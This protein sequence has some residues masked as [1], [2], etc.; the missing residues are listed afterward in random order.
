MLN[1]AQIHSLP[2]KARPLRGLLFVLR[3]LWGLPVSM[4]T[5]SGASLLAGALGAESIP[6]GLLGSHR[7]QA[8]IIGP[9]K[10]QPR[11]LGSARM[12]GA[13]Y[14]LTEPLGPGLV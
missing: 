13:G 12:E 14:L 7:V 1:L 11:S 6:L 9:R 5:A 10:P 4:E 8:A 2:G 3:F